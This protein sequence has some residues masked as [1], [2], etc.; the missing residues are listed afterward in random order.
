MII[1]EAPIKGNMYVIVDQI[2]YTVTKVKL[3]GGSKHGYKLQTTGKVFPVKK[4]AVI[5]REF[6]EVEYNDLSH[7]SLDIK[8]H[9]L[10]FDNLV[11]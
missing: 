3:V 8:V 5:L 11:V 2:N 9:K 7:A 1:V 4:N 6:D 10:R